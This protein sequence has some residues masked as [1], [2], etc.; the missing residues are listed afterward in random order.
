MQYQALVA[1]LAVGCGS[2]SAGPPAEHAEEPAV[3]SAAATEP[4]DGH[5]PT[6][7][8]AEQ[9]RDATHQG[10]RYLFRVTLGTESPLTREM[11]FVRVDAQGATIASSMRDADGREVAPAEE[12]T[13]TWEELRQ[14]ALFP[15]RATTITDESIDVAAGHFETRHY[16]VRDDEE[17]TTSHFWFANDLP[18]APVK[19]VTEHEG[20]P[21]M[22]ME[23]VTHENP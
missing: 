12:S 15:A 17:G 13:V 7:Y 2:S 19:L 16:T 1:V 23:L 21:L 10:R 9:I 20:T 3:T 14:H 4:A 11:R 22:T 6:P 18:G 8:T 5:A